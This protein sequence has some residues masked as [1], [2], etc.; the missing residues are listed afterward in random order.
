MMVYGNKNIIFVFEEKE[1]NACLVST[2]IFV[3]S[4]PFL[5]FWE[6]VKIKLF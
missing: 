1:K 4:H 2:Y 6:S 3:P 5:K